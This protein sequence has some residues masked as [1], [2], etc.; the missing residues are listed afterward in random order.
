[1]AAA[2]T[3]SHSQPLI[4]WTSTPQLFA[5]QDKSTR[6]YDG[7]SKLAIYSS[8]FFNFVVLGEL[9]EN[10]LLISLLRVHEGRVYETLK[11]LRMN[12]TFSFIF[13]GT[14]V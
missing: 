13:T 4:P 14:Q 12:F 5:V 1:M 11:L 10:N 3:S 6:E 9:T 8:P 2:P 7:A